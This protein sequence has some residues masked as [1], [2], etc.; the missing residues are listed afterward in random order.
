MRN[1][2]ENLLSHAQNKKLGHFYIVES[3]AHEEEAF[4]ILINFTHEFIKKYYAQVEKKPHPLTQLSDHPDVF[5]MGQLSL[6]TD[7]KIPATIPVEEAQTLNRFFEFKSVQGLRK[8]AIITQGHRISQIVAN[9]WLKLLEEPQGDATIFLLNPRG[10]RLL[11]TIHSRA[12]HLRLSATKSEPD[13]EGFLEFIQKSKTQSLS[14]F[15]EE[16][17]RG[18]ISFTQRQQELIH[19]ESLKEDGINHKMALENWLK[20]CQEFET[21]HQPSATKW[22]L[23]YQYLQLHVLA[24]LSH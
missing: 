14:Q 2:E 1:L 7:E 6:E 16:N 21:F 5:V 17:T 24:R 15:L 9:K 3:N 10:Q 20:S 13:L 8:F 22:T 23:F 19:W 4:S 11:E 12:Q 18:E